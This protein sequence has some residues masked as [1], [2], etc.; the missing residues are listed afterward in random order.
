[1]ENGRQLIRILT[2]LCHVM[3]DKSGNHINCLDCDLRQT[4]LVGG[5]NS[6][7]KYD[8]RGDYRIRPSHT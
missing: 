5:E 8:V 7:G 2:S 6:D 3:A 4:D 1:M